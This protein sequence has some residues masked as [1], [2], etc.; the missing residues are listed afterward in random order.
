MG[1]LRYNEAQR[2]FVFNSSC[3][4]DEAAARYAGFDW[5]KKGPNTVWSTASPFAALGFWRSADAEAR[6]E[7]AELKGK[8]EH[9]WSTTTS[10]VF[11]SP[12]GRVFLPFQRAGIKYALER[13]GCLIAD[14]PG[15]GKTIQA[16][17]ISNAIG[18][19]RVL[20]VCPGNVRLHWNRAVKDWSTIE[21]VK[22]YPIMKSSD[23]V[24]PRA[25][26]VIVSYNLLSNQNLYQALMSMEFDQL[27]LDEA[28]YLKT[29]D[30]R[31]TQAVFGKGRIGTT[32]REDGLAARAK[33]VDALTG[34]PL[35]NRPRECYTLSRGLCWDA[36]DWLSEERFK[37]R[38]NPSYF[39]NERTGRLPELNARLR[40]HF[41][42][43]RDKDAVLPDLPDKR[44]E[45]AHIEPNGAI[46]RALAKER[47]L[48]FSVKD[49]VNP[50]AEILGQVSTVRREMGEAMAPAAAAHCK[51]LLTVSEIEKIVV[52]AWHKNVMETLFEELEDFGTAVVRGGMT[53]KRQDAE[54]QRFQRDPNARVFIGQMEAAGTGVDGLQNAASHV[55]FAEPSWVPKDN[56]Q[57]VDRCHRMGQHNNVIA[58]LLVVEGSISERVL[59]TVIEKN[60]VVH[61]TL[62]NR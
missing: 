40:T 10:D 58:Q 48:D 47:M 31:R 60:Q 15:L 1:V 49:L 38:Y 45:L 23:G 59:A 9:S 56:E 32:A 36:V 52:F 24:S 57:C 4:E 28:H 55:V 50:R 62:D 21:N 11:P 8:Y 44:Y 29:P 16:I 30:A 6:A 2:L 25:H 39:G 17:G 42:V 43:R 18:A 34:T 53:S 5:F 54:V 61:D 41:M 14:P 19:Q 20:V 7:L 13:K 22:T 26:F 37:H 12:S 46:R 27:I 35:P 3:P 51:F 33:R